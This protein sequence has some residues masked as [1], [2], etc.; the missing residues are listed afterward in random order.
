[1][2][3]YLYY[4]VIVFLLVLSSNTKL[5]S[6]S[7]ELYANYHTMGVIVTLDSEDDPENDA[8]ASIRY[9]LL[10]TDFKEGFPATR[11]SITQ[12]VGSLFWLDPNKSYEVIVTIKDLT[13][14]GLNGTVLTSTL[15]TRKNPELFNSTKSYFV[16][17]NGSGNSF[18]ISNPGSIDEAV[19][20][21]QAGEEIVLFGGI[22]YSGGFIFPYEGKQDSPISIRAFKD[23]EA[24]FDGS[25]T[26]EHIWK[27]NGNGIFSTKLSVENPKLVLVEGK[28]LYG[29]DSYKDLSDLI[30]KLDGF[31]TDGDTLYV[32]INGKNPN[33]IKMII[34]KQHVAFTIWNRNY[35]HFRNL[36][37]RYFGQNNWAKALYFYN[38]S[39]NLIDSC[40]FGINNMGIGIK[41]NSNQITIQ[42][43]EFFDDTDDW[44]W[45]SM[46]AS[47]VESTLISFYNP[48][49]GRGHVIRNNVF[50]D[51]QDGLSPGSFYKEELTTELDIYNNTIYNAG[52][53]GISVDGWA[54]NVRVWNNTIHD[55]LVG[56]SFAPINKGPAYAI[57]NVIY[58]TGYGNNEYRGMS[59]KFNS[60][61]YGKSGV[62]Y[63]FHN[64]TDAILEGV[65]GFE[66]RIPGEWEMIYS[67]NNAF[68]GN[69]F[70]HSYIKGDGNRTLNMDYDNLYTSD[71]DKFSYW[72]EQGSKY[73]ISLQEFQSTTNLELNGVSE[74]PMFTSPENGDFVLQEGSPLIDAGVI[75]PGI[76]SDFEGEKPDIGAKE[77]L[78]SLGYESDLFNRDSEKCKVIIYPNPLLSELSI[79]LNN[80]EDEINKIDIFNINGIKVF[81][82]SSIKSSSIKLDVNF[83]ESGIYYLSIF[84][85]A[86]DK[87]IKEI[88]VD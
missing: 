23:E 58:N 9:R 66:C 72:Y 44:D 17:P 34:S 65:D 18:T 87:L 6:A 11:T 55:V 78:I 29:Y 41:N 25:D 5:F 83:H 74:D 20:L 48:V 13:S 2:M 81:N 14:S 4:Y 73:Y 10:G 1:M 37:F 45:N 57:R 42:N 60:G 77:K 46:K 75:I 12:F 38:S 70:A 24:I 7:L 54:S 35:F 85:K 63:L 51:C 36:T 32:K 8:V 61:G 19:K 62:M 47:I 59:F 68:T 30:W 3:K 33:D 69:R 21:V 56:I 16:S 49:K 88:I 50:H 53:D 80:K 67:R 28:R 76:N 39:Y 86:G 22:Y 82:N 43:S 71:I 52:D 15:K 31:Y 64:T 79:V 84:T 26:I 27:E 40:T